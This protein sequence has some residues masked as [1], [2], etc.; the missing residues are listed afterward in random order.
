MLLTLMLVGM[1]LEAS[2]DEEPCCQPT[3]MPPVLPPLGCS[4]CQ[5]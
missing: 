4:T 2:D 5:L 3:L 1:K